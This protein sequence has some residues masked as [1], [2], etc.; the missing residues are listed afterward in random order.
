MNHPTPITLDPRPLRHWRALPEHH[1]PSLVNA[2]VELNRL[3]RDLPSDHPIT[4]AADRLRITV[5]DAWW[6]DEVVT[7]MARTQHAADLSL[8]ENAQ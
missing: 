5:R 1:M 3:S 7:Q 8:L 2:L 4:L 6:A